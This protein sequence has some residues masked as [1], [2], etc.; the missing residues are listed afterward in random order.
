MREGEKGLRLSKD[1]SMSYRSLLCVSVPVWRSTRLIMRNYQISEISATSFYCSRALKPT[2][3]AKTKYIRK[4]IKLNTCVVNLA[5]WIQHNL[6]RSGC[7]TTRVKSP[8]S[9]LCFQFN[10]TVP[11]MQTSNVVTVHSHTGP[12]PYRRNRILPATLCPWSSYNQ[13]ALSP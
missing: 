11:K 2:A 7:G 5:L 10:F 1:L 4:S 12:G 6:W 8:T 3:P 13:T 9:V